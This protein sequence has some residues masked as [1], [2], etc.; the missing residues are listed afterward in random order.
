MENLKQLKIQKNLIGN[1]HI[2]KFCRQFINNWAQSFNTSEFEGFGQTIDIKAITR[3]PV[4]QVKLYSQYERRRIHNQNR[5]Y[6][7]EELEKQTKFSTKEVNPWQYSLKQIE[8]FTEHNYRYTVTG[9]EYLVT[10]NLCKGRKEITCPLCGGAGQVGCSK[11][12]QTGKI[13]CTVCWGS[14]KYSC[15]AC[16]GVGTISQN[17]RCYQCN[18]TGRYRNFSNDGSS[19]L[20]RC[21]GCHGSG[22]FRQTIPC[23]ACQGSGKLP[24]KNCNGTGKETCTLCHGKKILLC[25]KCNHTGI[26]TCNK[27]D[28]SGKVVNYIEIEQEF[29]YDEGTKI[30]SA[31]KLSENYPDILSMIDHSK[32]KLIYTANENLFGDD[33]LRDNGIFSDVMINLSHLSQK[34]AS[35]QG[36]LVNFQNF[37]ISESELFHVEYNFQDKAYR[38]VIMGKDIIYAP[39]NPIDEIGKAHFENAKKFYNTNQLEKSLRELKKSQTIDIKNQNTQ[40]PVL[41]KKIKNKFFKNYRT[42]AFL[43]ALISL[44]FFGLLAYFWHQSPRFILS[45]LNQLYQNKAWISDIHPFILPAIFIPF[46]FFTYKKTV[47]LCIEKVNL[48]LAKRS[49]RLLFAFLSAAFYNL[50]ILLFLLMVNSSGLLLV[51]TLIL[52]PV[53][54]IIGKISGLI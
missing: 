26:I 33:H 8:K 54:S 21:P 36:T 51:I 37:Q 10:C 15:T 43:G 40:I 9:S 41:Y 22:T 23:S 53:I 29:F 11:C 19:T 42:G 2:E 18:G 27:C 49:S 24:C 17:N 14:K 1:F 39:H 38:L 45:S 48:K 16:G 52:K 28:G 3:F 6:K 25:G 35:N 4:Y 5:P 7:G 30:L 20:M 31:Q 13:K 46:S 44:L 50:G 12:N 32:G 47:R 34:K